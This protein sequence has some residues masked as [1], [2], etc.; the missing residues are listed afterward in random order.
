MLKIAECI[1]SKLKNPE[2]EATHA[3]VLKDVEDLCK[4]YPL[5]KQNLAVAR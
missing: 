5:Y 3:R 4:Q 2:D 1:V